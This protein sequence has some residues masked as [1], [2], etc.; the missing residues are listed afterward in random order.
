MKAVRS[1]PSP[2]LATIS[3]RISAL[4][5]FYAHQVLLGRRADNPAAALTLPRRSKPLPKTLTP[6]EAE[7]LIAAASGVAAPDYSKNNL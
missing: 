3:R 4:R 1:S 2:R 6:G 5:S 7:K